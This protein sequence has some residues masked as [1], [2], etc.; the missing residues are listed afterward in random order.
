ML[1]FQAVLVGLPWPPLA[2]FLL[3]TAAS[4]PVAFAIGGAIRK[5][6]RL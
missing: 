4:I 5:P 1:A 3:V 6:L 2:K